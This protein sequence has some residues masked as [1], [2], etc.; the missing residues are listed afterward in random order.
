MFCRSAFSFTILNS[1]FSPT[2]A[3]RFFVGTTST[4][5]LGRKASTPMF[6]IRPPFKLP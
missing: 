4:W 6:T 3:S 2:K 5:E 1:I